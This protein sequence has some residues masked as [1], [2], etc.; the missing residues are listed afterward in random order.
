AADHVRAYRL[1][2]LALND[3]CLLES[4]EPQAFSAGLWAPHVF[5]STALMAQLN[6]RELQVVRQHEQAH[7]ERRDSL[8]KLGFSVLSSFFPAGV[9]MALRRAMSLCMEQC[10]DERAVA[11]GADRVDVAKT[12]LKVTRLMRDREMPGNS[13]AL[14]CGFA[15][16]AVETRVHYLLSGASRRDPSYVLMVALFGVI[17]LMCLVSVDVL[18]HGVEALLSHP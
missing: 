11:Q 6:A 18:H 2:T 13:G 7:V 4:R 5:I 17:A 16:C 3:D 12:L 9:A 8:K 10:A 1:L 14:Q 15:E